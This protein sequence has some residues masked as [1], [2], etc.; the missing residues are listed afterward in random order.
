MIT[1]SIIVIKISRCSIGRS[2]KVGFQGRGV[3][4]RLRVWVGDVVYL[5][6]LPTTNTTCTTLTK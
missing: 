1:C 2:G 4:A 3:D 5:C 6:F